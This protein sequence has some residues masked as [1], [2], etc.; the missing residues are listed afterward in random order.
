MVTLFSVF[1]Q[2]ERWRRE[3]LAKAEGSHGG[4]LERK[5]VE[6]LP[7]PCTA[8]HLV[9]GDAMVPG[10]RHAAT[11]GV[12][13]RDPESR[14]RQ[15]RRLDHRLMQQA[16]ACFSL[17][18]RGRHA[19]CSHVEVNTS[20]QETPLQPEDSSSLQAKDK[21]ATIESEPVGGGGGSRCVSSRFPSSN[22]VAP[23]VAV[24]GRGT[25]I[26]LAMLGRPSLPCPSHVLL[27]VFS[28]RVSVSHVLCTLTAI[29]SSLCQHVQI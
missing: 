14:G 13:R 20:V 17:Q 1:G 10:R 27:L 2:R 19:E 11:L 22:S 16:A 5:D 4:V 7:F 28:D 8:A 23:S 12:P 6:H 21:K 9:S 15:Y 29:P 3:S 18:H 24:L 26:L 25:H